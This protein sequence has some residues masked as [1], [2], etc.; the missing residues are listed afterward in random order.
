MELFYS[1]CYV[2]IIIYFD[3]QIS[4]NLASGYS[5]II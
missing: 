3:A 2:T 5:F 4:S 1:I